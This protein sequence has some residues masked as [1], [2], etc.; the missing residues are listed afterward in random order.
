MTIRNSPKTVISIVAAVAWFTFSLQAPAVN[1]PRRIEIVAKRFSYSPA[2]ITVKKGEPVILALSSDDVTHG[3]KFDDL[4]LQTEVSKG[5][6]VELPFTPA[7]VGDF[8]GRCSHF[9][10]AGHG[11]MALT[12][13]VT[14]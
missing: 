11:G 6:P 13:H 5:T 14:E 9:C 1:A 4:D 10:G 8:V 2:E 7:K 12:I 3:L